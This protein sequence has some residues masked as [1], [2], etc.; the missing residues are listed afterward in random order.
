MGIGA[1]D[2]TGVK[3]L[4]SGDYWSVKFELFR[5]ADQEGGEFCRV[6]GWP[7]RQEAGKQS[8]ALVVQSLRSVGAG[9]SERDK[10]GPG[11]IRIWSPQGI[12]TSDQ[13]VS[14]FAY[15]RG[16]DSKVTCKVTGPGRTA[17][18]QQKQSRHVA[19]FDVHPGT[20]SKPALEILRRPIAN[21]T[22]QR[23]HR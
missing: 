4:P 10:R 20:F 23:S 2:R 19:R 22:D 1:L 3:V 16:R 14:K 12:A 15:G 13:T 17:L 6:V 9:L 8:L 7:L 18:P 11:V 5:E 21:E